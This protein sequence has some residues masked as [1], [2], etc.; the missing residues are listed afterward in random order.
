MKKVGFIGLGIMGRPMSKNLLKAGV[1]LVVSDLN[2]EAVDELVSLGAETAGYA[3]RL[4]RDT[5]SGYTRVDIRR[6]DFRAAKSRWRYTL[7]PVW[8]LTYQGRT[9]TTY[10]YAMNGQTGETAGR[11]PLDQGR[12]FA[13]AGL[14]GIVILI[15]GLIGGYLI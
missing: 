12:L 9:G 3:E 13:H 2:R 8:V 7:L 10:Y 15:L 6:K 14:I 11:L 5:I 4:V 1:N